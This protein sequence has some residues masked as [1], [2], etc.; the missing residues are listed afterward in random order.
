MRV[1]PTGESVIAGRAAPGAVVEL[2]RDGAVHDRVTADASGA[3]S[4][5][6]P[7][8]PPG[9]SQLSLRAL[10]PG[11]A[12]ASEQGVTVVVA[13]RRDEAPLVALA[14][15]ERPTALLSTPVPASPVAGA[16]PAPAS[17]EAA[18]PPV[19][20]ETVEAEE[21]GRLYVSGRAP[22]G[23]TVR[24]YLNDT[25]VA[26]GT[27]TEQG[28]IA[29]SIEVGVSP[30]D[31]RVRLDDAE[32]GTGRVR[33]RAQVPFAMPRLALAAPAPPRPDPAPPAAPRVEEAPRPVPGT[34]TAAA[35]TPPS[36]PLAAARPEPSSIAA[37]PVAPPAPPAGA[38]VPA[39]ASPAGA[40][41][42]PA[43]AE[44]ASAD[45]VLPR[46]GDPGLVV[47]PRVDTAI[48]SRGD[49]LWR[50]SRRIYGQGVRFTVIYDAN[51]PQIRD[52]DRIYPG[53]VFVL[54]GE[55]APL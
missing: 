36:A 5:V 26:S 52:P 29:F 54:P 30:G 8:L 6:A 42:A 49:S 13:P 2:L 7:P 12:V 37:T 25:P 55:G 14:S 32:A 20:V 39:G 10:G 47:V 19:R 1:E 9:P 38:D 16:A 28:R 18:R 41:G 35:P 24:L 51:Q 31:Y 46:A 40:P 27:A 22:P 17:A 53:Q 4:F 45:A 15:P 43:R 44:T 3:F 48:V 21:G 23:A 33:S 11:G 34:E 50:I